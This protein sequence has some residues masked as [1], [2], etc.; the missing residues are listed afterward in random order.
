MGFPTWTLI[1]MGLTF[2]GAFVMIILATIAQSP[3]FAARIGLG[4]TR[5]AYQVKTFTGYALAFMLLFLG[6]F[7][8][9]VPL[10]PALVATAVPSQT[11]LHHN[12]G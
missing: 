8:A 4:G 3:S 7:L 6:F 12:R 11:P 5:I 10:D 2:V 1:G 9:G